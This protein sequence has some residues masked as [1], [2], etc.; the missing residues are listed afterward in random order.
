MEF[1]LGS[2]HT[3][4]LD[5]DVNRAEGIPHV[6]VQLRQRIDVSNV[7]REGN[8]AVIRSIESLRRLSELVRVEVGDGDFGPLGEEELRG[9]PANTRISAGDKCSASIKSKIH[10]FS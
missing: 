1:T 6:L 4:R 9:M 8:Q 7:S 5:E 3:G 10:E 2:G